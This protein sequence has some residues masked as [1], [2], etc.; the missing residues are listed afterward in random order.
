[1]QPANLE[2]MDRKVY[3][4]AT[5]PVMLTYGIFPLFL[6]KIF[7]SG[8]NLKFG[9]PDPDRNLNRNSAL[10]SERNQNIVLDP[11]S[12][13]PN[14]EPGILLNPDLGFAESG[15]TFL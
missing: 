15:Q 4:C 9:D 14:L 7:L 6:R 2:S 13:N 5:L 10:G 12:M 8:S 11:E 1:M 3:F